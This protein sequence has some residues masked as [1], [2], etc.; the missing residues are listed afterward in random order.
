MDVSQCPGR[1]V[2]P[3]V[4]DAVSGWRCEIALPGRVGAV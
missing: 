4:V 2:G 1:G 3:L